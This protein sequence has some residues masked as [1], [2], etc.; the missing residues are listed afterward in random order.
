[1]RLDVV[2]EERTDRFTALV[3]FHPFVV[4]SLWKV[5]VIVHGPSLKSHGECAVLVTDGLNIARTSDFLHDPNFLLIIFLFRLGFNL[6]SSLRNLA[7]SQVSEPLVVM[8]LSAPG[9]RPTVR[10]RWQT[11]CNA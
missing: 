1:M 7:A 8:V 9:S 6:P 4:Q 11:L 2:M 3:S 5:L 10:T